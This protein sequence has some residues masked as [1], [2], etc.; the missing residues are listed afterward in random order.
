MPATMPEG[1]VATFDPALKYD[2]LLY[3]P[4]KPLQSRELNDEQKIL[5]DR[6]KRIA[7]VLFKDGAVIRDGR[8]AVDVATGLCTLEAGVI[9]LR[10]AMRGVE[11]AAF[12]IPVIGTVVVGI[13]LLD[14]VID[15]NHPTEGA[16]LRDLAQGARN[17][18]EPGAAR[19]KVVGT[20]GMSGSG[21]PGE[22]YPVYTIVDGQPIGQQPPPGI[23]AVALAIA[24][25]D[26]QSAGG[27]YASSGLAVTKLADEGANQIYSIAEGVARVDGREVVLPYAR[28]V[29]Y[30]A[31]PNLKQ[32]L[33][34]PHVSAGGTET[35][36]VR[37]GPIS[38]VDLVLIRA[39]KHIASFT[40]GPASGTVDTLPDSPILSIVAVNQGGTWNGSTFTG[41]T[42]FVQ[43]TDYKLTGDT[44]D[45]SLAGTST[46]TEPA[47]G[48]TYQVVY[49][50]TASVTPANVTGTGFQITGAVAGSTTTV[51]YRWKRPRWDR[52]CL[53]P[54]GGVEWV[55]GVA[56]DTV[57]IKPVAGPGLLPLASVYQ[58]WTEVPLVFSSIT[59]AA[60]RVENDGVRLVPMQQL[61]RM[62][63]QIDDLF[64]VVSD[65]QLRTEAA[66]TDPTTKKGIFTDPFVDDSKRD[67]GVAQTAASFD[68][69]LTLPMTN[70]NVA[71]ATLD[72]VKTLPLN[73]AGTK[74][75]IQQTL[76]TG[77][78]KVNPY[79]AF[80]PIPARGTLEPAVDFW[81]QRETAWASPVTRQF[82]RRRTSTSGPEWGLLT[83][84]IGSSTAITVENAVEVASVTTRDAQFLRPISVAFTLQGFGPGETLNT[85][86]F[87]GRSVAFTA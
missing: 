11:P 34:E 5:G 78:M 62:Q 73:Q 42:T 18:S 58:S 3:R 46:P 64:N 54:T 76:K 19:L 83:R 32:I 66:I 33:G 53:N 31:A 12:T 47:P 43:G 79:D 6:V 84:F 37:R 36:T 20:W 39:R 50:Y 9:Y 86:K 17:F 77:D 7:D 85:V 40:R 65:H 70:V 61:E 8:I 68:G 80:E 51:S 52:L 29:V 2:E 48:S 59:V 60:R 38:S 23:D 69:I 82:E 87:D 55:E 27:Y 26:R 10:G 56:N 63:G 21:A 28:R 14:S 41:G 57:P 35:V 15:E 1:Y 67:A 30:P 16:A 22:F 71:Q 45:W 72:G 75:V 25:Y 13:Y 44:V 4:G 74:P 24:S 49:E 81:T